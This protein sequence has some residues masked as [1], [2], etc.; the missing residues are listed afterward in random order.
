MHKAGIAVE[1]RLIAEVAP[2][3]EPAGVG[4]QRRHHRLHWIRIP[5]VHDLRLRGL[6]VVEATNAL[7]ELAHADVRRVGDLGVAIHDHSHGDGR[8]RIG[9]DGGEVFV[10]ER[11]LDNLRDRSCDRI[12]VRADWRCRPAQQFALR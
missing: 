6:V 10:A 11:A 3:L 8:G 5:S 9:I 7:L 12:A 4:R 1:Y 2:A